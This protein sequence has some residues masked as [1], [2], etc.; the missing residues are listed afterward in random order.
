VGHL[1]CLDAPTGA[2]LWD[3][4]SGLQSEV[5]LINA[6]SVI[7]A[8]TKGIRV[9]VFRPIRERY[10]PVVELQ[11][12]VQAISAGTVFT[13]DSILWWDSGALRMMKLE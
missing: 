13:G 12:P 7:L 1:F 10:D 2:N 6:G 9:N 5:P 11:G 8:I 3:H 4:G